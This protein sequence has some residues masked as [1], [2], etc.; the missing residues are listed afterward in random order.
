MFGR[1]V[2]MPIGNSLGGGYLEGMRAV[3]QNPSW[4]EFD[5]LAM[6][7]P[8]PDMLVGDLFP[9]HAAKDLVLAN[10]VNYNGTN[11]QVCSGAV[12]VVATAIAKDLVLY[13]LFTKHVVFVGTAAQLQSLRLKLEGFQAVLKKQFHF[14]ENGAFAGA[15]GAVLA[16]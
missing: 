13:S 3:A 16:R 11:G 4:S 12:S 2:R 6:S 9:D 8:T 10:F 5:D 7:T 14:P 15:V 1:A